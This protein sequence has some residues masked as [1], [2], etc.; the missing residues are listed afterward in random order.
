MTAPTVT[1]HEFIRKLMHHAAL[2]YDQACRAYMSVIG[3]IEDSLAN[4]DRVALGRIGCLTPVRKP[5]RQVVMGFTR[6]KGNRIVRTRKIFQLD[7]RTDYKFN[8]YPKF[9]KQRRNG[10]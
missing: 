9:E 4:G 5:P 6:T 3:L 2:T 7:E 8:F 10:G 1:R